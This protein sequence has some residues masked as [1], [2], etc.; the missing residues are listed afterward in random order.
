MEQLA[1]SAAILL[2]GGAGARMG[3]SYPDKTL[4]PIAGK[5]VFMYPLLAIDGSKIFSEIVVVTRDDWQRGKVLQ[6]LD[7]LTL[8]ANISCIRGGDSRQKS[9]LNALLHMQSSGPD[10]VLIHDAA[11]PLLPAN[12]LPLLLSALVDH[13]GAILAHRA[14]DTLL[15]VSPRGRKYLRRDGVWHVET[16]QMF[17][18]GAILNAY[19]EAKRPLSDDS[20]ALPGSAKVK[21]IENFHPN[22]KITYPGD[23]AA[24]EAL[25]NKGSGR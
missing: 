18:Y 5:P 3:G 2:M 19:L 21:I 25:L 4:A 23:I 12:S 1:R 10:F 13:D 20:S 7:G 17:K 6:L 24:V 8:R 16:P 9:A 11:R 15:H 14:T 22:I